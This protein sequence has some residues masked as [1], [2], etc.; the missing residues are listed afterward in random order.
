MARPRKLSKGDAASLTEDAPLSEV[1]RALRAGSISSRLLVE[2]AVQRRDTV[3]SVLDAYTHW[4]PSTAFDMAARAD[5]AFLQRRDLG[6][7]Q[8]IPVSIKDVF[9]L[10]GMPMTCSHRYPI[11]QVVT[12]FV[13]TCV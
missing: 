10:E 11:S 12:V 4:G 3:S 9:S 1:A 8:G 7:L 13:T 5:E 2:R 6:F